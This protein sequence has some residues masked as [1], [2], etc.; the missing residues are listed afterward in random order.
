MNCSDIQI[1]VKSRKGQK[2]KTLARDIIVHSFCKIL[3]GYNASQIFRCKK[4][5]FKES[6]EQIF[7]LCSVVVITAFFEISF[8][9]L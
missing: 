6:S 3:P 7:I 8:W 1:V 9:P 4:M 2:V 5:K